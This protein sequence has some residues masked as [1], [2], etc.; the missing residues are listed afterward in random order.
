M[1]CI[2]KGA[3]DIGNN[4]SSSGYHSNAEEVTG[5]SDDPNVQRQVVLLERENQL[6]KNE[7][8]SLNQEMQAVIQRVQHTQEGLW[9]VAAV[10]S[11]VAECHAANTTWLDCHWMIFEAAK[12]HQQI[13]L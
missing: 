3:Q 4:G 7:V 11:F 8:T 2:F 10:V 13:D 5:N 12:K 9:I 1:L 6:L